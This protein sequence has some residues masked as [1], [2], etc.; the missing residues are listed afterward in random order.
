MPPEPPG[1][2]GVSLAAGPPLPA[3]RLGQLL[4]A[5][6]QLRAGRP[7]LAA[8]SCRRLLKA[9]P[10]HADAHHLLSAA[11]ARLGRP[12][13]AE[14][15]GRRAVELQPRDPGLLANLAERLRAQGRLDEAV[16]CYR[17]ALAR[18]PGL[19][20]ALDG[21]ARAL[22]AAGDHAA[23]LAIALR[24][25]DAAPER[26]D[27]HALVGEL[28]ALLR[29]HDAA[30]EA[31]AR[32]VELAPERAD[33]WRNLARVCLT[34]LNL[35]WL[36]R[37]ACH[38]LALDPDDAEAKVFLANVR[39]RQDAF[40]EVRAL[41]E[42]VPATGL[43]GAN[44]KNLLG[45]TLARQG[46]IEDGLAAL[47]A[48]P[49]LAPASRRAADEPSAAPELRPRPH[50]GRAAAGARALGRALRRPAPGRPARPAARRGSRP[51]PAGRLP[52]ARSAPPFGRLFRRPAAAGPRPARGRGDL[53]RLG[54]AAGFVQRRAAGDGRR[55][56]RRA[57]ARRCGA[58]R[59][60]P[61]RSDRHPG[62]ARRPHPRQPAAGLR[63]PAGAGADR[64]SR[65][66][67][68]HRRRGDR[69]PD[70]RSP[71]GSRRLRRALLRDP[72]PAAA[73]LS[74]LCDAAPCAGDR[75]AAGAAQR[76][77]HLRLV[78]QPRQ[79]QPAGDRR[80]G[81]HPAP[82]AGLA[83]DAE[84]RRH[85]RC[86]DQGRRSRAPSRRP[87][88]GPSGCASWRRPPRRATIWR[89]TTR[90]TSRSIRSPT[91]A[92]PPPARRCGWACR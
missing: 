80:L 9:A 41:L 50:A 90:S 8:R 87:A 92:P 37:A 65:L 73:L 19:H 28:L 49:A 6:Q 39:F 48:V 88:S 11:L 10:D 30:I 81:R 3:G 78:Q 15:H 22:A 31:L 29:D 4:E 45:V 86:D 61:R 55:L 17:E 5:Q 58:R 91:T 12:A 64:L 60:H 36:E 40:G 56:G 2:R 33:W 89:S 82:G 69:L 51:A 38:L 62:R 57:P 42:T 70:H 7:E 14:R 71:G 1:A 16:A 67:Q 83:P 43:I 13:A 66:S 52:V 24:A 35:T 84:V 77:C 72:D 46:R 79:G 44:A 85:R 23:A 54:A 75:A 26:A 34:A 76:P 25:R 47:E 27:S 18:A 59:P 21:L 20:P 53:L 68:H 63:P 74:R 32:A